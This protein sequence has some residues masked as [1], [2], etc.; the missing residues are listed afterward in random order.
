MR[1][2]RPRSGTDSAWPCDTPLRGRSATRLRALWA[3]WP[4]EVRVLL[5]ALEK[6]RKCRGFR[7]SFLVDLRVQPSRGNTRGNES[8]DASK[9]RLVP[10][11]R[12]HP[13]GVG[14]P[15]VGEKLRGQGIEV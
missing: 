1:P 7:R 4:V 15:A 8:C 3:V 5:G 12:G 2:R 14:P 10:Q 6:P 9:R 13:D 11:L